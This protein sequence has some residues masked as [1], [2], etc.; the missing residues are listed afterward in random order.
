M[1][2][3]IGQAVYFIYRTCHPTLTRCQSTVRVS[4]A[5]VY[6]LASAVANP[7]S[8]RG[9]TCVCKTVSAMQAY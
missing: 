3:T 5:C 8:G 6:K 1:E 7:I 9:A 2:H 4:A